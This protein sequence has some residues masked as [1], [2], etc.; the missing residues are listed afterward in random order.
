MRPMAAEKSPRGRDPRP[1]LV[2]VPHGNGD[3]EAAAV[4]DEAADPGADDLR[5]S[6]VDEWGRSQHLRDILATLYDPLY[7]HWFRVEGGGFDKL[8]REGG[9]LMVPTPA[10]A[11]PADA[12][13]IMHGIERDL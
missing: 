13:S 5:L 2:A 10:G 12:P 6:D 3:G 9:R 11:I 8:P 7:R 1:K 4:E